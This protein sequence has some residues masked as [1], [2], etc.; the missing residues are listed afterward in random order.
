LVLKLPDGQIWAL[1]IKRTT[2]PK[3]TRG[4]HTAAEELRAEKRLLVFA[5]DKDVPG[6]GGVRALPL[7]RALQMLSDL[8]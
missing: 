1:E 3:V 5:G 2:T 8:A 7:G 4:F 6:P